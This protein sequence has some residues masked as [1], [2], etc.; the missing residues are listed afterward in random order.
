MPPKTVVK[1]RENI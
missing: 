1:L